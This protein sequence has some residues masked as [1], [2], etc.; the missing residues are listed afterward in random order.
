MNFEMIMKNLPYMA[1]AYVLTILLAIG[2]ILGSLITGTIFAMLR[3][4]RYWWLHWPAA[5]YIDILRS[6]PLLMFI[7]WFFFLFPIILGHSVEPFV[8]ALVALIAFNTSYMAEVIRAGIQ[9]IPKTQLEAGRSSGLNYLQTMFWVVLP[10]AFLNILPAIV[11]RFIAL[12]MSSSLAYIIGVTEFFRAAH[13]I[14]N[15][16]FEPYTIYV[17]VALVYFVSCYSLSLLGRYL[18]RHLAP[19]EARLGTMSMS[20]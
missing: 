5:I 18:Q 1:D 14:N 13:N 10:Q 16:V 4:S 2:S 3:L 7:F 11:S 17:F 8:A 15:R 6:I 12:F 19:A 20:G 9:S